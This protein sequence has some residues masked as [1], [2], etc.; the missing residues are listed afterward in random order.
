MFQ[1]DIYEKIKRGQRDKILE[2]RTKNH[3]LRLDAIHPPNQII[4]SLL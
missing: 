1:L 4:Y 3:P 2:P